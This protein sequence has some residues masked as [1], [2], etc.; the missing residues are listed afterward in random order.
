MI[1]LIDVY[2]FQMTWV[3]VKLTKGQPE[4]GLRLPR[5]DSSVKPAAQRLL[6][7]LDLAVVSSRAEDSG[8]GA[9]V[10]PGPACWVS[11]SQPTLPRKPNLCS[12]WQGSFLLGTAYSPQS[13]K[14]K[15]LDELARTNTEEYDLLFGV[16][17]MLTFFST[18]HM[19]LYI[20]HF[21]WTV[22]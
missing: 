13:I 9:T 8:W 7:E 14:V 2:S 10:S 17:G 22:F 11:C 3:C 12:S 18:L 1:F 20:L 5:G 16:F 6:Y 4:E 21:T 19:L 15:T